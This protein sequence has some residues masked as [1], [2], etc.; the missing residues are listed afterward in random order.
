MR[1]HVLYVQICICICICICIYIY[2]YIYTYIHTHTHSLSL[3]DTFRIRL[4]TFTPLFHEV[5]NYW[6]LTP[7][8][9][10]PCASWPLRFLT[11]AL[12]NPC[13]SWPL[14]F[15]TPALPG[16]LVGAYF[17]AGGGPEQ[18]GHSHGHCH[19][20]GHYIFVMAT[21]RKVQGP[22]INACIDVGVEFCQLLIFF[23]F[24]HSMHPIIHSHKNRIRSNIQV[25][26][27][28]LQGLNK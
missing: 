5:W 2:I 23:T 26:L 19:G 11:P 16:S 22:Y 13:A 15:L 21:R 1:Q 9:L 20:H 14:R 25:S 7:A 28:E 6:F 8:L 17:V 12:L 27:R 3:S 10:D 4:I 24:M 18:V